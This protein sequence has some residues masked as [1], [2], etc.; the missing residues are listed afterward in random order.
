MRAPGPRGPWERIR[1]WWGIADLD[2]DE[3]MEWLEREGAAQAENES[4]EADIASE[5][6]AA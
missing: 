4:R 6:G 5:E 2:G 1:A 3:Q